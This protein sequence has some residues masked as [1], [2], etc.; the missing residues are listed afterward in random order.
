[1]IVST[2]VAPMVAAMVVA[3]AVMLTIT[4]CIHQVMFVFDAL[5]DVA[6]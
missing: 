4:S 1:M 3:C 6:K 2:T 5:D